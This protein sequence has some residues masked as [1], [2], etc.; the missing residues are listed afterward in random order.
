MGIELMEQYIPDSPHAD[1]LVCGLSMCHFQ[2]NGNPEGHLLSSLIL[3]N[4]LMY[5]TT[6]EKLNGF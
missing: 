2:T 6:Q 3:S 1:Y 5:E 4:H